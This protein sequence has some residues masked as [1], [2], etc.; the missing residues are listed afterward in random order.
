[1]KKVFLLFIVSI[2]FFSV[3][4]FLNSYFLEWK[5]EKDSEILKNIQID[6]SKKDKHTFGFKK[7]TN[8]N[9]NFYIK[10]AY[11]ELY[12]DSKTIQGK[13]SRY[14][15]DK[16]RGTLKSY[17]DK[18]ANELAIK[19]ILKNDKNQEIFNKF[20]PEKYKDDFEEKYGYSPPYPYRIEIPPFDFAE[21]YTIVD[22]GW[23]YPKK[24]NSNQYS[25]ELEVLNPVSIEQAKN[26]NLSS[27][28]FSKDSFLE[29]WFIRI[30]SIAGL[31]IAGFLFF[32]FILVKF[33][34]NR[35]RI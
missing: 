24:S 5:I 3:I 14:R 26:A 32:V 30:I 16:R 22:I 17:R 4:G 10:I 19:I 15:N 8:D 34:R 11:P 20:I 9:T 18:I 2:C 27:S 13:L 25:L 1:M 31:I 35:K 7:E 21:A 23:L 29:Y 12:I 33:L 6:L 28:T